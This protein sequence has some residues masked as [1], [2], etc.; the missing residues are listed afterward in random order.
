MIVPT[1]GNF[2]LKYEEEIEPVIGCLLAEV[3]SFKLFLIQMDHPV[4]FSYLSRFDIMPG[5]NQSP[6]PVVVPSVPPVVPPVVCPVSEQSWW[7]KSEVPCL[8]VR[9]RSTDARQEQ[10]FLSTL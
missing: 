6:H 5:P 8:I 4:G 9:G 3:E 10:S 7:K 2:L 1:F